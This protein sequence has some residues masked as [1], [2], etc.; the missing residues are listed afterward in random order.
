MLT[1]MSK[2]VPLI[3]TFHHITFKTSSILGVRADDFYIK[4]PLIFLLIFPI[5]WSLHRKPYFR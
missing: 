1:D 5:T 3:G 4:K 2:S